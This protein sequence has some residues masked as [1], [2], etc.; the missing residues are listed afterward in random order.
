VSA[1]DRT[2]AILS[3]WLEKRS[4][5]SHHLHILLENESINSLE[6]TICQLDREEGLKL[7]Q[8][9]SQLFLTTYA[10][11]EQHCQSL[12]LVI[13]ETFLTTFWQL[14]LPLAMG[15][16]KE[17]DKL[18]RPFIQG[19]LAGQGTGKTTLTSILKVILP[20]LGK[21]SI[22]ISIDDLYKTN[23][24]RQQLQQEDPRLKWRGP[25]PTHDVALGRKIL[26]ELREIDRK[27]TIEIPRFDK[28]AYQGR[29]DRS[30]EPEIINPVDI[31]LFEGWFVGVLPVAETAFFNPP[32][33]INTEAD[34]AFAKDTNIRL[35]SYL[36]LWERLDRL[37]ILN[38]VD[39]R[40]S[41]QWRKEAEHQTIAKGKAGMSDREIEEFVDYFWK[42]LH[43]ELFIRPL[44]QHPKV[45]LVVEVNLDRS[46]F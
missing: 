12:N 29:G 46:I 33:P 30:P 26:D 39:Y 7:L 34:L 37:L 2:P 38:P 6:S 31:V 5:T 36:P 13:N 42:A 1:V 41:K 32:E 43:P 21:S 24:E 35:Q 28:S 3:D 17:R 8:Q 22:E 4:I 40:Y 45:N 14:W 18:Q 16:A 10:D 19:I 15:L 27:K 23:A 44:L 25:P 11:V 20:H 9:R